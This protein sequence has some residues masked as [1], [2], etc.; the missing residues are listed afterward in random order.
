MRLCWWRCLDDH[1]PLGFEPSPFPTLISRYSFAF[2]ISHLGQLSSV[3]T[4]R[5]ADELLNNRKSAVMPAPLA[6]GEYDSFSTY[7]YRCRV[8]NGS[9][10]IY[11]LL[12]S[13]VCLFS[14]INLLASQARVL[15]FRIVPF[16]PRRTVLTRLRYRPHHRRVCYFRCWDRHLREPTS[17]T[18]GRSNPSQD[19]R[20]T[21]LSRR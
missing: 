11:F 12:S 13:P 7:A 10:K 6:K 19:R 17:S 2:F 8:P 14:S 15:H 16:L 1:C 20:G 21:A 5:I 18:M 4:Y 9:P 3:K